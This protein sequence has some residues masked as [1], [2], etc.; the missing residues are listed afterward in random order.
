MKTKE[1]RKDEAWKEYGKITK[2]ARKEYEKIRDSALEEYEKVRDP[3]WKEYLKE[4]NEIDN[5]NPK[6]EIKHN[7]YTY[8]LKENFK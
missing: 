2:P 8:V 3:A 7:G 6:K 4:C 5:E 1:Q